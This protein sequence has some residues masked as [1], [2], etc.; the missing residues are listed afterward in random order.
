MQTVVI[1]E[2]LSTPYRHFQ[3]IFVVISVLARI[4]FDE[5]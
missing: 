4:L 1:Q 2:S 5:Q 3:H